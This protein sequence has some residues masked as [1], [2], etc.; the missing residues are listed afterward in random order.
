MSESRLDTKPYIDFRKEL[1]KDGLSGPRQTPVASNEA[2]KSRDFLDTRSLDSI[3][4]DS[5]IDFKLVHESHSELTYQQTTEKYEPKRFKTDENGHYVAGSLSIS[6]ASHS[7]FREERAKTRDAERQKIL[8]DTSEAN[9]W[10]KA[11]CTIC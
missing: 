3:T 6:S 10:K 8:E 11:C 9:A 2:K 4:I 1:L 5:K 7:I